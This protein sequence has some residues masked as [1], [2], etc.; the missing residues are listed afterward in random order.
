M[1][2]EVKARAE[3]VISEHG[4][5][6]TH[7]MKFCDVCGKEAPCLP[8]LLARDVL[9]LLETVRDQQQRIDTGVCSWDD[10]ERAEKAEA[11]NALLRE[12]LKSVKEDIEIC[13]WRCDHCD[14]DPEMKET[15][16]YAI[17]CSALG[18]EMQ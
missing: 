15:D 2:E 9:G 1:S 16:L 5:H 17:V 8:V 3:W 12:S 10:H 14:L 13:N 6:D 4:N 11:E 18:E 7:G